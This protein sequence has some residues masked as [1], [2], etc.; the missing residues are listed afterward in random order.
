[1]DPVATVPLATVIE[2]VGTVAPQTHHSASLTSPLYK[3]VDLYPSDGWLNADVNV[4]CFFSRLRQLRVED[5]AGQAF[6]ISIRG[7][8][9]AA[10]VEITGSFLAGVMSNQLWSPSAAAQ[11]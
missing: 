10:E 9:S 3:S 7:R 4:M 6:C 5:W 11:K 2:V 8:C 1:M